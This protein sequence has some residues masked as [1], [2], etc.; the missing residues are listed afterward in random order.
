MAAVFCRFW[1]ENSGKRSSRGLKKSPPRPI[2]TAGDGLSTLAPSKLFLIDTS[3][4]TVCRSNGSLLPILLKN[5]VI[6]WPISAHQITAMIGS[7]R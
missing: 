1:T 2:N 7:L 3:W 6:K 5:S 4:A